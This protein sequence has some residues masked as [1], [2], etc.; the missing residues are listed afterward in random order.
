MH[1]CCGITNLLWPKVF[2]GDKCLNMFCMH[3][4]WIST[5]AHGEFSVLLWLWFGLFTCIKSE[6]Y[7]FYKILKIRAHIPSLV[8]LAFKLSTCT[9]PFD[10]LCVLILCFVVVF[11]LLF[12]SI[13]F[14]FYRWI[15]FLFSAPHLSS[16]YIR[17]Q[18]GFYSSLKW[19]RW[20]HS[21]CA[22][23]RNH[24]HVPISLLK[25]LELM[26]F[27]VR[28]LCSTTWHI[29]MAISLKYGLFTC[30]S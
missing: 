25:P 26:D 10:C 23:I 18:I 14:L 16:Q 9:N 3:A 11:S 7:L 29:H 1:Y 2:F 8:I 19:L 13:Q 6:N 30:K 28:L 24:P 27:V 5:Q 21:M 4:W 15:F 22:F 20:A 12:F 17:L